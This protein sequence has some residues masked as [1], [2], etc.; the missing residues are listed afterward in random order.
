MTRARRKRRKA[1]RSAAGAS[2]ARCVRPRPVSPPAMQARPPDP[3]LTASAW[4]HA[5]QQME[6]PDGR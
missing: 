2:A 1:S 3:A 4:A 6:D 5:V